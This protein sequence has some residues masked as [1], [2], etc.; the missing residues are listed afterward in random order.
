[1]R[2]NALEFV[3]LLSIIICSALLVAGCSHAQPIPADPQECCKRLKSRSTTLGKFERMCIGLA[4]LESRFPNDP[5]AAK[6]IKEGLSICK[7]V[8]AVKETT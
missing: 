4:F 1:M 2:L 5:T 8:F 7:Y 3:V 6:N